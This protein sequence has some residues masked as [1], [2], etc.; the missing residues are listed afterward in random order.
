M[1]LCICE[2]FYCTAWEKRIR[3][4]F[5]WTAR[6]K[7]IR[8]LFTVQRRKSTFVSSVTGQRWKSAFVSSV[9]GQRRKSA[10]AFE[11]VWEVGLVAHFDIL[12][13][14]DPLARPVV[15]GGQRSYT[16]NTLQNK[17]PKNL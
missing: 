14:D 15:R 7:R 8:E 11:C 5:Y 12:E 4:L 3:E 16:H 17:K 2:L 1:R 6:E 13:A 9:T 10:F